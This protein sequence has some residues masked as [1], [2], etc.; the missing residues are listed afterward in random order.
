MVELEKR[1]E[2]H[3]Y[4][5]S[6]LLPTSCQMERATLLKV[7]EATKSTPSSPTIG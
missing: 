5:Y 1:S 6:Q 7:F 3:V 4:E 2:I